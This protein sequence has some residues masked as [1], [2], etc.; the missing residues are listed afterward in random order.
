MIDY[1]KL[2][3]ALDPETDGED[4]LR[5]RTAIVDEVNSDGTLDII[6]SG[7]I[8]ENVP[9]LATVGAVEGDA[10]QVQTNLGSLLVVG[11][12][13]STTTPHLPASSGINNAAT[14]GGANNDTT[15]G[16]YVDMAGTGS[17]TSFNFTKRYPA[18]RLKVTSHVS[19]FA[20]TSSSNAQIG[21]RIDG[22]DHNLF[23]MVATLNVHGF[24]SATTYLSGVTS[25]IKTA[26]MRWRRSSGT[27]TLRRD[28]GDWL[29]ISVEEV[30]A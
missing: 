26:Q 29:S 3:D 7:V 27:G 25:G 10:V 8:I 21:M 23:T 17:V 9:R 22:V 5:R 24:G 12:I 20:V 30:S 13:A 18:S 2:L 4:P 15:S 6:L 19:M 1:T 28:S 14:T 16:T 11:T